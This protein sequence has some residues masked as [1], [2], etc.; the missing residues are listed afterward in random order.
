[1]S[2]DVPA[3]QSNTVSSG[4]YNYI[5]T[6]VEYIAEIIL[7]H[8]NAIPESEHRAQ[9]EMQLHKQVQVICQGLPVSSY[10]SL[11]GESL[12]KIYPGYVDTYAS[13]FIKEINPPPPKGLN[14]VPL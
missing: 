5:D 1:M 8:E 7:K 12:L 14:P 13:G 9:K 6:Y 3:A 11:P 2:I 4:D 10:T